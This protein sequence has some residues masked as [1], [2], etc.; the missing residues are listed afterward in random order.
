MQIQTKLIC[1]RQKV[2][3]EYGKQQIDAYDGTV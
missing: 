2:E 1:L 3:N